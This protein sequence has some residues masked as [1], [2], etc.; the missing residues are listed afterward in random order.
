MKFDYIIIGGG[1]AGS[2]L[3]YKLQAKGFRVK[4]YDFYNPSSSSRVAAG[5]LN[6][7]TGRRF[8][9]GWKAEQ[10]FREFNQSYGEMESLSG[11]ALL[12]HFKIV[13]LC[14]SLTEFNDWTA[15]AADPRYKDFVDSRPHQALDPVKVDDKHGAIYLNQGGYLNT[16]KMLSFVHHYLGSSFQQVTKRIELSDV[17][18]GTNSV[19]IDGEPARHLVLADG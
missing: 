8:T 1:I 14:N 7:V 18:V 17:K 10:V 4:L 3:A 9:L 16:N 6:P 11:E 5:L 15:K 12:K 13:R 2:V 19:E